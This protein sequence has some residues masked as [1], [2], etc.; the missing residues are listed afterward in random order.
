MLKQFRV[1]SIV[2]RD[3]PLS[4]V[5]VLVSLEASASLPEELSPLL[6]A[7][8][9]APPLEVLPEEKPVLESE[10]QASSV[11]TIAPRILAYGSDTD[12]DVNSSRETMPNVV[13]Q[14]RASF[15]LRCEEE[16][17]SYSA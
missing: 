12:W 17:T 8:L 5:L 14:G 1:Q 15:N 13:F 7:P 10:L 9:L 6:V 11:A 3:G 2:L 4:V 16:P